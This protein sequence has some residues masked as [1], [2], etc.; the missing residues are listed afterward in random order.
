MDKEMK[1]I[2]LE[3]CAW[4]IVNAREAKK[5]CRIGQYD[6]TLGKTERDIKRQISYTH[7]FCSGWFPGAMGRENC[8]EIRKS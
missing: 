7:Q 2:Y 8:E 3:E 5:S 6:P 4:I 1:Q